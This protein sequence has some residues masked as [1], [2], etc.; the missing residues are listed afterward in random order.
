MSF[1]ITGIIHEIFDEVQVTDRFKKMA[2]VILFY[3]S[4]NQQWPE[5]IQ[6]ELHGDNTKLLDSYNEG[7]EVTV[8]FNMRG[9]PWVNPQ[10]KRLWFNTFVARRFQRGDNHAVRKETTYGSGKMPQSNTFDS[11]PQE[12]DL[13]F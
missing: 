4:G 11:A 7:E 6:F 12:D 10:G 9:R 8:H 13:P 2:F 3:P 5:H 1:E